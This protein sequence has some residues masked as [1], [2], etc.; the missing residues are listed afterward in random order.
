MIF[1]LG[2]CKNL[3]TPNYV[4]TTFIKRIYKFFEITK[5]IRKQKVIISIPSEYV[6]S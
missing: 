1:A 5:L 2:S 6:L 3:K 4:V